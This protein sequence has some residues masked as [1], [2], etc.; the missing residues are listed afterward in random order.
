VGSGGDDAFIKLVHYFGCFGRG[1]T[2][3]LFDAGQA[4]LFVTWVDALGAVAAVKVLVEL[5]TAK[6]LKDWN[7]DLFSGAGVDC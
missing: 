2:G 3:D 7:A 6:P 1:A 4:V 5:E